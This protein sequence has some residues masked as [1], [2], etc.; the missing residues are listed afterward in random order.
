MKFFPIV[1]GHPTR[2]LWSQHAVIMLQGGQSGGP[3]IIFPTKSF[4]LAT[5]KFL[6]QG[7]KKNM[8]LTLPLRSHCSCTF[9][10]KIWRM[11]RM[12]RWRNTSNLSSC[13]FR[14][15]Q[16]SA[17]HRSRFIRIARKRRYFCAILLSRHPL[18]HSQL[19]FLQ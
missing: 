6:T 2:H 5:T 17:P 1:C 16:V 11:R 8:S 13:D 4:C 3:L 18:R 19:Q 15:D 12:L 10:I 9:V 7:I 14:S